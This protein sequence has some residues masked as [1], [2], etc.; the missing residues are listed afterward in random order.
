M[1]SSLH[2]SQLS[3]GSNISE[4]TGMP[5]MSRSSLL[6]MLGAS[7]NWLDHHAN[8]SSKNLIENDE[9]ARGSNTSFRLSFMEGAGDGMPSRWRARE[10]EQAESAK[11]K[12]EEEK[13][14]QE[15]AINDE[16]NG[17][18][19]SSTS[20]KTKEMS[21][22]EKLQ[23]LISKR[24]GEIS[25]LE[26]GT[27]SVEQETSS[28][29]DEIFILQKDQQQVQEDFDRER[30]KLL[31]EIDQ[32]ESDNGK[33]DYML[34][35][36]GVSREETKISIEILANELKE[37]R[38]QLAL[39]QNERDRQKSE[40]RRKERSNRW[41]WMKSPT[42]SLPSETEPERKQEQQQHRQKKKKTQS[43]QAQGQG[44]GQDEVARYQVPSDVMQQYQTLVDGSD[45]DDDDAS[46]D[47]LSND[48]IDTSGSG[49]SDPQRLD[50]RQSYASVGTCMSALT[51]DS[52][53]L[54]DIL[55]QLELDT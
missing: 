52:C 36:T 2:N 42:S 19:V 11:Q 18:N 24:E 6:G 12:E 21:K 3:K 40:R 55:E 28:I 20:S 48:K 4:A 22:E 50:R 35:E 44:Q 8:S 5:H 27:L 46:G 51:L 17:V 37:A 53:D 15:M 32:V 33:L 23:D 47:N 13:R 45:D 34:V 14:L 9:S 54:V 1:R 49:N 31:N 25:S 38:E 30:T 43:A 26:K 7:K 41:S 39:I 10:Q 16:K 29:R